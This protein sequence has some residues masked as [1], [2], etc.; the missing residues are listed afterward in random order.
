MA[1]LTIADQAAAVLAEHG[2]LD[3]D[4]LT[5]HL[6]A[7]GA[8]KAKNPSKAVSSAIEWSDQV[9][10]L[11]GGRYASRD[12]LVGDRILTR[13]ITPEEVEAGQLHTTGDL[14]PLRLPTRVALA[15]N[16][17]EL[18][19][20][21][22]GGREVGL[23][24]LRGPDGWLD[25]LSPGDLVSVRY[26]GTTVDVQRVD[27]PALEPMVDRQLR[28]LLEKGLTGL[29]EWEEQ[30]VV[31]LAYQVH[32]LIAE[33]ASAFT[34]AGVP[35]SERIGDLEI[36]GDV[37]GRQGTD[38]S[39]WDWWENEDWSDEAGDDDEDLAAQYRLTGAAAAAL[40]ELVDAV[41]AIE[42]GGPPPYELQA[43]VLSRFL[44]EPRAWGAFSAW[45]QVEAEPE[46]VLQLGTVLVESSEPAARARTWTL[47]ALAHEE[48]RQHQAAQDAVGQALQLD[49]GLDLALLTAARY[50]S[51]RGDAAAASRHLRA[52]GAASQDGELTMLRRFAEPPTQRTGRNA[53][54]PCGS[55]KKHKLCCLPEARHPLAERA[56]WLWQ[57][58]ASWVREPR[59]RGATLELVQ[60][61]MLED[62]AAWVP[63]ALSDAMT[64]DLAA[65]GYDLV[66][67]FL[68]QRGAVLPEDERLLL[69][70]WMQ[71]RIRLLE[72]IS[73]RAGVIEVA[74]RHTDE[75]LTLHDKM[76]SRSAK[77][78][79]VLA[80][81]LLPNGAGEH[82]V[83]FVVDV[84]D[85][86]RARLSATLRESDD[87]EQAFVGWWAAARRPPDLVD[88]DGN[89]V[90]LCTSA[91]RV[92]DASRARRVLE[93]RFGRM[94]GGAVSWVDDDDRVL[95]HLALNGR[96]LEVSTHTREL[97][98]RVTDQVK[99]LLPAAVLVRED[100]LPTSS[101]LS[102][103]VTPL[104]RARPEEP[105]S[106]EI[107]QVLREHLERY[108]KAWV[109]ESIPAL[110]GLTPRQ[111]LL[112]PA[113]RR[114]LLHLLRD[115]PETENGMSARRI[116][117]L[118][119]LPD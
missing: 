73:V 102:G 76:G 34:A 6:V 15:S 114:E 77:P 112:D 108:E 51:D 24:P 47:C 79:Q 4:A 45:C 94:S 110:D 17:G 78:G 106:P 82:I 97:H 71:E 12:A 62:S 96:D 59:Q 39:E 87:H 89:E 26:D 88:R 37:V 91:W 48:L 101:I 1:R 50:A 9:V 5:E 23:R 57:K 40:H 60:V 2:V 80:G 99:Q 7:R 55:G 41:V 74:D 81:R 33:H 44:L 14:G 46:A 64:L 66:R 3:L 103:E 90:V 16:R 86:Q 29:E 67:A 83:S 75:H 21:M 38:W 63:M 69:A 95:A 58:L 61:L 53:P 11:P 84:P 28:T 36:H 111:A 32:G 105:A 109:D 65:W 72:V 22:N 119:D 13:R 43:V 100:A 31:P 20:S 49:R 52:A 42:N 18:T 107:Q 35:L 68:E 30:P 19:V 115:M 8:T 92:P 54:C 116:R 10:A 93:D 104:G 27:A 56:P 117:R 118:L 113:M 70:T 85:R 98:G 25:D